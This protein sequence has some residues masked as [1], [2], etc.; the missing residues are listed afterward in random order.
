MIAYRVEAP[1]IT[2]YVIVVDT[3]VNA[4]VVASDY[5]L[6]VGRPWMAY[7]EQLEG[8]GATITALT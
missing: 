8:N 3:G 5:L 7:V 1:T 6:A 4:R 2:F